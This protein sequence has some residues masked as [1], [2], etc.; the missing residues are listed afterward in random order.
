MKRKFEADKALI[1]REA[2]R[3]QLDAFNASFER[4]WTS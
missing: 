2:Y 4:G 1:K 3:S